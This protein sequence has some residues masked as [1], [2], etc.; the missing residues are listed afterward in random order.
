VNRI[1]TLYQKGYF[2]N[3]EP[4][5]GVLV[6]VK[7]II[8]QNPNIEVNILFAYLS[9]SQYALAEKLQW[10]D[11]YIPEVEPERRVLVPF[12]S[13]KGAMVGG[14]QPGDYLLDDY[15]KNLVT[16]NPDRGIKLLNG[17]NHTRGTWQ[18]N[19]IRYD[20]PPSILARDITRIVE[21]GETVRDDKPKNQHRER[22][23]AR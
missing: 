1:E 20:K 22:S 17:I 19:R 5:G 15:T 11:K 9:D 14:L 2:L 16:W 6:A 4:M 13:D 8:V 12:G 18:G 3:L 23:G 10:L 7:Q 21:L